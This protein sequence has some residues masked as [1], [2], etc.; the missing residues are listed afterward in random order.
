ML[1]FV[2]RLACGRGRGERESYS[3]ECGVERRQRGEVREN[4]G[5]DGRISGALLSHQVAMRR[6]E[7]EPNRGRPEEGEGTL[8]AK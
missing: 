6:E 1:L 2:T 7:V 3:G 8:S 4:R 5:E